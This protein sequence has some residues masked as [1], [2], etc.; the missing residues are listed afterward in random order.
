VTAQ[1][2]AGRAEVERALERVFARPEL[3]D[4]EPTLLER[5]LDWL[6]ETVGFDRD[7]AQAAEAAGTLVNVLLVTLGV[8]L[9]LL[10]AR[11]L[12]ARFRLAAARRRARESEL[13]AHR[14]RVRGLFRAAREARAAGDLRLA[15]RMAL[16]A[17]VAGLGETGALPYRDSWTYREIV[18]RGAAGTEAAELL[19]RLVDELESKEYGA[20]PIEA[21]DVDRLEDLCRRHLGGL[22]EGA[23][24]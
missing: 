21:R 7:P 11:L 12:V 24:A 2:G 8:L 9:G 14:E 1:A 22:L 16:F 20:A 15:L 10:V 23:A 6:R 19:E 5:F 13:E 4:Q 17:L 3:S 18:H